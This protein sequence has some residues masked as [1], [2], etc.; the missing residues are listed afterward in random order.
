M[1][2]LYLDGIMAAFIL[3]IVADVIS[4]IPTFGAISSSK[5][6][7]NHYVHK[8]CEHADGIYKHLPEGHNACMFI[9]H[10]RYH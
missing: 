8:R 5:G 6:E 9:D 2:M 1:Q 4:A 7:N 3:L 10:Y